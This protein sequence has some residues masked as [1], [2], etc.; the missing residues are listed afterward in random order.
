MVLFGEVHT[1][2]EKET[3]DSAALSTSRAGEALCAMSHSIQLYQ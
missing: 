1:E 3:E 2:R